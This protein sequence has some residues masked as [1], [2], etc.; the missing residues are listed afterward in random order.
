MEISSQR[1]V[2]ASLNPKLHDHAHST[3]SHSA[4]SGKSEEAH[5]WQPHPSARY[6]AT[7]LHGQLSGL[8]CTPAPT[9]SLASGFPEHRAHMEPVQ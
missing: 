4:W 6:P 1:S 9:Y 7:Q 2:P 3:P 8:P 5:G